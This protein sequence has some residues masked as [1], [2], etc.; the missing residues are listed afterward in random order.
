MQSKH[1]LR[2]GGAQPGADLTQARQGFRAIAAPTRPA[3]FQRSQ[4]LL[5]RFLE[6]P[7]DGHCLTHGLHLG[8]Q[9]ARAIGEFL[10]GKPRNFGHHIINSGF[11]GGRG[12]LRNIVG[13]FI[14]GVA[15][16]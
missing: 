10:E 9:G 2:A 6:R 4:R 11:K 3:G 5:E 8:G 7:P 12:L 16:R 13:D 14:Q 1:S 15:H